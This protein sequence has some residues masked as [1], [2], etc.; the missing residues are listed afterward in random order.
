MAFDEGRAIRH[1][2][3]KCRVSQTRNAH[4]LRAP[5]IA[6]GLA[7]ATTT[8]TRKHKQDQRDRRAENSRRRR[9]TKPLM[10]D[11]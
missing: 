3:A 5:I 9:M 11:S 6:D 10:A 8:Q 4:R 2:L 7:G 1:G